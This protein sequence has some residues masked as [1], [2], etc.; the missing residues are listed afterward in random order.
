MVGILRYLVFDGVTKRMH[1][2][3]ATSPPPLVAVSTKENPAS[4]A[5]TNGGSN[6]NKVRNINNLPVIPF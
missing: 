2:A 6:E 3:E 4:G 1:S 5:I